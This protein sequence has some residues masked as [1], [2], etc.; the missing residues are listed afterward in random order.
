[1]FDRKLTWLYKIILRT[2]AIALMYV[3]MWAPNGQC[4]S[5]IKRSSI[6]DDYIPMRQTINYVNAQ[7]KTLRDISNS[8]KVGVYLFDDNLYAMYRLTVMG[9]NGF[10]ATTDLEYKIREPSLQTIIKSAYVNGCIKVM[11]TDIDNDG[12]RQSLQ[13]NGVE[14]GV[15]CSIQKRRLARRVAD[16]Y[17]VPGA[18]FFEYT[19]SDFVPKDLA[20]LINSVALYR[21]R[22]TEILFTDVE[23]QKPT[24]GREHSDNL[25]S[26]EVIKFW[27]KY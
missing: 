11:I 26:S 14:A 20:Q 3:L 25:E 9:E 24:F 27:E 1:M 8:Y 19:D 23:T 21:D 2:I 15:V 5:A 7:A 17:P 13:A 18:I 4:P 12:W 10:E 6:A 22:L 16:N